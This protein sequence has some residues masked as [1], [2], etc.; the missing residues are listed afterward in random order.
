MNYVSR[1]LI[2]FPE[3]LARTLLRIIGGARDAGVPSCKK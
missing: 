1:A 2:E 3:L